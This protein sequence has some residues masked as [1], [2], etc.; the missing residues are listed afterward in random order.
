MCDLLK[1]AMLFD[2]L[3]KHNGEFPPTSEALLA[4]KSFDAVTT[5]FL[6]AQGVAARV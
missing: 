5:A 4:W 1:D 3:R 6:H 2:A